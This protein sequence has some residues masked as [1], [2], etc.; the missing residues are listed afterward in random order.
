MN[1]F[2]EF[3]TSESF[4]TDADEHAADDHKAAKLSLA[5]SAAMS[6][7]RMADAAEA[8]LRLHER[9]IELQEAHDRRTEEGHQLLMKRG[10]VLIK[11]AEQ[12]A[13]LEK[14]LEGKIKELNETLQQINA[15]HNQIP[16]MIESAVTHEVSRRLAKKLKSE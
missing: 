3:N 4:I 9:T 6:L 11:E 15:Y 2:F 16:G 10:E 14:E 12:A 7:S 1:E 13:E 8:G 5:F